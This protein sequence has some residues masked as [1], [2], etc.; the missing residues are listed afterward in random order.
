MT[1]RR[2]PAGR[3]ILVD[4]T[5]W[6]SDLCEITG[7]D[8]HHLTRALRVKEGDWIG[9]LNGQGGVARARITEISRQRLVLRIAERTIVPAP[10]PRIYLYQALLRESEM[11]RIVQAAV[12]IGVARFVAVNTA[13]VV[14]RWTAAKATARR[15]RW[16]R[17]ALES[18]KQS[19][20]PWLPEIEGPVS[21][22]DAVTDGAAATLR[23]FGALLP[24]AVPMRF[25]LRR[26]DMSEPDSVAIYV[27]PEGDFTEEEIARLQAA[28]V[29][30]V[31]FAS[32]TLR[33]ET[34]AVFAM[35]AILYE[36]GSARANR[37]GE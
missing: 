9:L 11:D 6:T 30:P 18:V 35:S 27:G 21:L 20:Q 23:V 29:V 5:R 15:E 16:H 31:S 12:E 37:H 33:A 32:T 4:P 3:W 22:V 25:A 17:I 36:W 2:I 34:A 19:G 14:T 8:H 26:S 13:R 28:G 10:R 7:S 1:T 24:H